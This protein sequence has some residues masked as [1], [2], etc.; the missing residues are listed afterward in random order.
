MYPRH[1]QQRHSHRWN[2]PR[3]RGN[4]DD[5]RG[6]HLITFDDW[7]REDI[8]RVLELSRDLKTRRVRGEIME[9]LKNMTLFMIFFELKKPQARGV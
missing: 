5:L 2:N 9:P 6:R 3:R 4:G 1:K 7:S 8:D